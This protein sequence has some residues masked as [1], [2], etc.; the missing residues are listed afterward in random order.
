MSEPIDPITLEIIQNGLA[1]LAEE[2]TLTVLRTA[3]S[4][5]LRE[6]QDFSVGVCDHLGQFVAQ[7]GAPIHLGSFPG[8]MRKLVAEHAETTRPGDVFIS[9]D[10]YGSAGM[11]LP[12]I[13]V[14]KPLFVDDRVVGYAV[15]MGHQCD[16]G[17][18]T[19]GSM[20]VYA[21]EIYQEGLRIP[22]M[23]FYDAG[24]PNRT[25]IQ[26]IEK[27]VRVPVLVMGDLHA[28]VAAC[29][30]GERGLIKLVER[31]GGADV[32]ATYTEAV[33][34]YAERMMREE[35]AALPNGV[36]K[37]E[38]YTDGMGENP[39]PIR[40]KVALTIA[41]DGVRF[42]WDGTSKQ[43]K[44]AINCPV[45]TTYSMTYAAM[46]CMARTPLPNCQGFTR[47]IEMTAPLG[48][49]VN[50]TEPA[51]C[52]SRGIIAHR[53]TDAMLGALAQVAP[54]RVPAA[55]EG[56]PT[57][58]SFGG[59]DGGEPFV[60]LEGVGGT[61]GSQHDRDGPSSIFHANTQNMS[62][63]FAESRMPLEYTCVGFAEN[64]G[65]PGRHRG[66]YSTVKGYRMLIDEVNLNI[67][68]DRRAN[69]PYGLDG[70]LPGTPSWNIVNPGSGQKLLPTCPMESTVLNRGDVFLH[71][72][73]GGGGHGDPLER[74]PELVLD[75]VLN[76]FIT[77]DYAF[78]AY[79]VAVRDGA[80]DGQATTAR[81]AK[82]AAAEPGEPAYLRHFHHSIGID[83]RERTR[84]DWPLST[85]PDRD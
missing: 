85:R 29:R 64:S 47:P 82:L 68:S 13:F 62:V 38:D 8:V 42:D 74:D 10:P 18:I 14:I 73:P 84:R 63:E 79:G 57:A 81:R 44:A 20:A 54:D 71:V 58:L 31:Y 60:M 9:N 12:D 28:Q 36:Y 34:D 6:T 11:H 21:T 65:G 59:N 3:Y 52:A 39:E 51:A 66:G 45:A 49:I 53:M 41:G 15:A 30:V 4:L 69:L 7:T 5:T 25:L 19:P 33:H 16:I 56:G 76:E 70:G 22:L 48:S 78:D 35:I 37:F 67:R 43:V 24:E 83:P 27:N 17:G 80:V 61:W 75:A 77:T 40:F 55:C 32:F 26:L 23:K 50:P 72:Q 1:T 46:R 2:M